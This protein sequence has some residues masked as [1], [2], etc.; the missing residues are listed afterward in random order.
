MT[1]HTHQAALV[2]WFRRNYPGDRI[3]A[4]P[5]GGW[6]NINTAKKLKIEGVARGVPDLFVPT[7][8]RGKHGLFIE[9]KTPKGRATPQQRDWLEFLSEKGYEAVLCYGW[10]DAREKVIE[11]MDM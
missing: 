8:R 11:Y 2:A 10:E 3:F 9:M 7:P 4:I 6:R 5:N 1:E